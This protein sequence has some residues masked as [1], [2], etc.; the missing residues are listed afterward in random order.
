[1]DTENYFQEQSTQIAIFDV[2]MSCPSD[3][4]F[5]KMK[6]AGVDKYADYPWIYETKTISLPRFY[7]QVMSELENSHPPADLIASAHK[8]MHPSNPFS[9]YY[10]CI[11]E[12]SPNNRY[13]EAKTSLLALN[14]ML[15]IEATDF[16]TNHFGK[17]HPITPAIF[18]MSTA[19]TV[20]HD[21]YRS[22]RQQ[23]RQDTLDGIMDPDSRFAYSKFLE[24]SDD[25]LLAKVQALID[26]Y[27][28][29]EKLAR[30][31][32]LQFDN[33]IIL[34]PSDTVY[35]HPEILNVA[36]EKGIIP[37]KGLPDFLNNQKWYNFLDEKK[38]HPLTQEDFIKPVI[39]SHG[40]ACIRGRTSQY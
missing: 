20:N 15:L 24:L 38:T 31:G 13:S 11:Q 32:T 36:K 14:Y 17:T 12:N 28:R 34:P 40:T 4:T 25:E 10:Q 5:S 27:P 16:I 23:F 26:D 35:F 2:L 29:W 21:I 7:K 6:E 19:K 18:L 3:H 22:I 39:I 1:M 33:S 30:E 9:T 37:F 8:K